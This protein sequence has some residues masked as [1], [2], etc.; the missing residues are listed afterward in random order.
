MARHSGVGQFQHWFISSTI[1]SKAQALSTFLLWHP[2]GL[3]TLCSVLLPHAYKMAA[4]VPGITCRHGT[5]W[6]KNHFLPLSHFTGEGKL[7]L[8]APNSLLLGYHWPRWE[9]HVL[10]AGEPEEAGFW[11][12]Q[13][14]QWQVAV[15]PRRRRWVS[16]VDEATEKSFKG[17]CPVLATHRAQY[18]FVAFTFY[19]LIPPLPTTTSSLYI[20]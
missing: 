8:E 19:P 10:A 5:V 17:P 16:T 13:P 15:Q 20:Q 1:S 14:L 12:C 18:M 6:R 7:F 4:T 3:L 9:S 11:H 2:W